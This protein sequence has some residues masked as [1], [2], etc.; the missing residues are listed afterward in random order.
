MLMDIPDKFFLTL[1]IF[2]NI[3]IDKG[4]FFAKTQKKCDKFCTEN[5]DIVKF[6]I[7]YAMFYSYTRDHTVSGLGTLILFLFEND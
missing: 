7:G 4:D 6:V 5:K 2:L 1:I 3:M